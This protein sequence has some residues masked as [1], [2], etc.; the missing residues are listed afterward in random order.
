M[1]INAIRKE[2]AAHLVKQGLLEKQSKF[3][4]EMRSRWIVL[5]TNYLMCFRNQDCIDMTDM[6]DLKH[7]TTIKSHFAKTEL[8]VG[9]KISSDD[10]SLN[11]RCATTVEKWCW[12]VAVERAVELKQRGATPYNHSLLLRTKGFL[13]V[14]EYEGAESIIIDLHMLP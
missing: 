5:T 13:S 9:F 10:I 3:L 7:V 14:D 4:K 8:G 1:D 11:F 2:I 6:I 12:I